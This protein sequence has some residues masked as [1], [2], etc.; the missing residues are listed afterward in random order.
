MKCNACGSNV[1]SNASFC[2]QCGSFV[3]ADNPQVAAQPQQPQQPFAPEPAAAQPQQPFGAAPSFQQEAYST[4]HVVYPQGCI[5][6]AWQDVKESPGWVGR[7]VLLGIIQCVPILN[8]FATGYAL[9]W[10]R[11]VPFGGKTPMSGPIF[12]GKNFEIGFYAFVIMLLTSLVGS[13]GAGIL[14][15]VPVLGQLAG[16]VFCVA[17]GAFAALCCVRI[18]IEGRIGAGFK[19]ADTWS[20]IMRNPKSFLLVALLP[21]AVGC[22]L[23]AVVTAIAALLSMGSAVP[24]LFLSGDIAFALFSLFVLVGT[25]ILYVACC[26]LTM[27]AT[28]V[29][30]RA[31][32]H[33][34]GRH[35]PE[36]IR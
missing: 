27:A 9:N 18:G 7:A 28:L 3:G 11:E 14:G 5:A 33:W 19:L 26:M 24:F 32:A 6:A 13:L 30:Y 17:L 31:L 10:A 2:P 1:P 35:A 29:A 23:V 12:T 25:L 20:A 15:V 16:L 4:A 22:V 36:W 34:V 8:F 21:V